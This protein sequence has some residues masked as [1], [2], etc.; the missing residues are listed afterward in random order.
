[1]TYILLLLCI[2]DIKL[3]IE[4]YIFRNVFTS[5]IQNILYSMAFNVKMAT[6]NGWN[7]NIEYMGLYIKATQELSKNCK[8]MIFCV[9][10]NQIASLH[11]S[12]L[13]DLVA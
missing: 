12:F 9:H 5:R 4:L 10:F 2:N 3:I 13:N 8:M 6:V 7:L 1:M 11:C